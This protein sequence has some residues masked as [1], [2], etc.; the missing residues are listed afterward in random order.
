MSGGDSCANALSRE[1]SVRISTAKMGQE[2]GRLTQR[3]QIA[4]PRPP[5]MRDLVQDL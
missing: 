4:W 3:G 5:H 2:G 1:S